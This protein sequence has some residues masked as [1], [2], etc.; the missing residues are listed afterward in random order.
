MENSLHWT[1]YKVCISGRMKRG[2]DHLWIQAEESGLPFRRETDILHSC[3][4]YAPS[5][6]LWK[7]D[8]NST[9]AGQLARTHGCI[10]WRPESKE[11]YRFDF[12]WYFAWMQ[13]N[14][15]YSYVISIE[16]FTMIISLRMVLRFTSQFLSQPNQS[17]LN[18]SR[19][20]HLFWMLNY[21]L[22]TDGVCSRGVW[23]DAHAEPWRVDILLIGM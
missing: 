23:L 4:V 5:I 12:W 13:N 11:W 22:D 19:T 1:C 7:Q 20:C 10:N 16:I 2:Q 21:T 15:Y 3:R 9:Q 18:I 8:W 14:T 6:F 17:Q